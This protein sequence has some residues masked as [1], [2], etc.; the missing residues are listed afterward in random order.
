[1]SPKLED[2][3][4]RWEDLRRVG[5]QV[6]IEELCRD[7]P[8]LLPEVQAEVSALEAMDRCLDLQGNDDPVAIA[9]PETRYDELHPN[10]EPIPGYHLQERLGQGGFGE[11]WKAVGP[12]GFAVALKFV[13]LDSQ[14]GA[15]ELQSLE[16][17]K[18]LHHPNLVATFGSWNVGRFL[19]VAM[20]LAEG[21]LED[22]LQQ[23]KKEGLGGVPKDELF[24]YMQDAASGIDYLN[25]PECRA[26]DGS[27]TAIQHRDIKPR[28]L[29]VVGGRAK[30]GDFGLLRIL[31]NTVT[32]HTGLM[33]PAYAPPEFAMGHTARASDQYSLAITY[34]EL[35]TGAHPFG[36]SGSS[37][38]HR[39]PEISLL[40]AAECQILSRALHRDPAARWPSCGDFVA[41]LLA[42]NV[43]ARSDGVTSPVTA[44]CTSLSDERAPLRRQRTRAITIG[45]I[46]C[47]VVAALFGS[48]FP[49]SHGPDTPGELSGDATTADDRG[50]DPVEASVPGRE[51]PVGP[52]I[53]RGNAYYSNKDYAKAAFEYTEAINRDQ[54]CSLAYA[55]RAHAYQAEGR[56]D[57]A[58]ADGSTAIDLDPKCFLAYYS[59]GKA[60]THKRQFTEAVGDLSKAI[61]LSPTSARAFCIRGNAYAGMGDY[62]HAINDYNQA[63]TLDATDPYTYHKRAG[64]YR[65]LGHRTLA[66]ADVRRAKHL[67]RKG[68]GK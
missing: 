20:E 44:A 52:F 27:G 62:K 35:R 50:P 66:D 64:A 68:A 55:H 47:V 33:T 13:P 34:Y 9:R 45:F 43:S 15:K 30:L 40:P 41:A 24:R 54:K 2:L 51:S 26:G 53:E 23:A 46:L 1:M 19:V 37:I 10:W 25:Q 59:R 4:L 49:K 6:S 32:Q 3:L 57:Q 14:L 36:R 5:R 21:T 29:L 38:V 18:S 65:S 22:R 63:I 60:M 31:K 39:E 12:G 17:L 11:V 16:L 8:E 48:W 7:H 56:D 28:N 67:E 42:C 61:E 58:I